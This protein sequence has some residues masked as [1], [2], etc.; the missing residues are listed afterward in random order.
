[1]AFGVSAHFGRECSAV[2][3]TSDNKNK[4]KTKGNPQRYIYMMKE[5]THLRENLREH[6][7]DS[8]LLY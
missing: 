5:Y 8:L 1:M 7:E 4:W 2:R 3:A 6:S